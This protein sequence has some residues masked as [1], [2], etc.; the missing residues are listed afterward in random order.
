MQVG[1]HRWSACKEG[2]SPPGISKLDSGRWHQVE[3]TLFCLA[4]DSAMNINAFEA[5]SYR[6]SVT[7]NICRSHVTVSI[8][9]KIPHT[10][11]RLNSG[12][13]AMTYEF[14]RN[15]YHMAWSKI[16]S[17]GI[18]PRVFPSPVSTAGS[19]ILN[20]TDRDFSKMW[21]CG[22]NIPGK[23]TPTPTLTFK[24]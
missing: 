4:T 22:F 12:T 20:Q 16:Q 17:P 19:L 15:V 2:S 13:P 5:D 3:T 23:L 10:H 7:V 24:I 18:L 21:A 11:P 8:C 1:V 9:W 14:C 6:L